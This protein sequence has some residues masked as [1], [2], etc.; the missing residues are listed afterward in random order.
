MATP[1]NLAE[2][3]RGDIA[4]TLT[5]RFGSVVSADAVAREA[6][7]IGGVVPSLVARPGDAA[8]LAA[9]VAAIAESGGALVALGRGARRGL[10]HPPIRYDVALLT[11]R[12]C[13]V[14]DYAP[15]DMTVTVE[16]GTTV[17][18]LATLL[19]EQ[20]QWLPIEPELPHL[21]TV[22]G[23]LAADLGGPLA[24]S[25]GRVRDFVIGVGMVTADGTQVR[26]GGRVVKNVAGYDA[27]KLVIGSLGTLA[28]VTEA[29]FKVRPMVEE[30]C[31]LIC[32][33]DGTAAAL[34]VGAALGG[35]HL[36]ML[37][38]TIRGDLGARDRG[39]E[40]VV[41][42]GG[43]AADVAVARA[44]VA[45]LARDHAAAI[46]LGDARI[47]ERFV[48]L[49]DFSLTVD[50]D[51]VVRFA[52]LPSRLPE[53]VSAT[54]ATTGEL[55]G[56]WQADPLRGVLTLVLGTEAPAPLLATLA[57]GADRL[58]AHMIVE[59]WPAELAPTIEVWRP[60]PPALPL[61]R[62]MKAALDPAGVLAPGRYVG[63]M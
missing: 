54:L 24:A 6:H 59:R 51:F 29:T 46:T 19:A 41:R 35:P 18:D 9:I 55:D 7:T 52:T 43:N 44:R 21:T 47:G 13:R 3:D 31:G 27:M 60:L 42:L 12:L 20:G 17:A 16:A 49:R 8:E 36:A 22:G 56:A 50:G 61:M 1:M 5:A 10:G 4:A 34:A 30:Q 32:A 62:R 11:E 15:A 28:V 40:V 45:T 38:V 33:T 63:R 14:S 39:P 2:R 57:A 25:Q 53:L 48:A 23:L 26:A 58:R 37:A